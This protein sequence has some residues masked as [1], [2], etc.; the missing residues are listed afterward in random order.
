MGTGRVRFRMNRQNES[1]KRRKNEDRCDER[2]KTKKSEKSTRLVYTGLK[3]FLV[4][5]Y[6]SIK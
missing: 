4:V 5:Y 2:L 3:L 1:K 6:E